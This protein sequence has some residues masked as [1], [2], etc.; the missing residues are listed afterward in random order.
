MDGGEKTGDSVVEL[1]KI[2]LCLV[3]EGGDETSSGYATTSVIAWVGGDMIFM[4][5]GGMR[6]SS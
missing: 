4:E 5:S 6:C 2:S 3:D 1:L